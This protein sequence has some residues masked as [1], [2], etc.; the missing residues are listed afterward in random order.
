MIKIGA[1]PGIRTQDSSF[2]DSSIL[3]P[4]ASNPFGQREDDVAFKKTG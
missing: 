3:D 4:R 2:R 1:K